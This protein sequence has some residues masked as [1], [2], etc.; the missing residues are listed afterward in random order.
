MDW[1]K[2]RLENLERGLRRNSTMGSGSDRDAPD[3]SSEAQS[4]AVPGSGAAAAAAPAEAQQGAGKGPGISA[5]GEHAPASSHKEG[6]AAA[7]EEP[8][9]GLA[10]EEWASGIN[11]LGGHVHGQETGGAPGLSVG[12]EGAL[13]PD[14]ASAAEGHLVLEPLDSVRRRKHEAAAAQESPWPVHVEG[15]PGGHV[16]PESAALQQSSA[17]SEGAPVVGVPGDVH[18]AA[19]RE[20]HRTQHSDSDGTPGTA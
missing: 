13:V 10:A 4:T 3:D 9:G 1:L 7:L 5:G 11:G 20:L 17:A 18:V 12:G 2:A 6:A 19:G 15:A 14:A 16:L 8:G